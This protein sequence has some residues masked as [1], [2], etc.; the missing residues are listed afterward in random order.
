MRVVIDDAGDVAD[1]WAERHQIAIVPVNIHFGTE[2]FLSRVE[3]TREAFYR[4]VGQIGNDQFPKTS[5][6]NPYQFTEIFRE[7]FAGGEDEILVITVSEGLSKTYESAIQAARDVADLGKVHV[8]DSRSGSAA[9][10]YMAVEA[11]RM[12]E[13]GATTEAIMARLEQMRDEQVVVLLIHSLEYAVRGGR[14]SGLRSAIASL[15]NIKPLMQ[16]QD[17]I[18]IEAGKVRTQGKALQFMLDF[19]KGKVGDRPVKLAI[20]HANAPDAGRGLQ[21]MASPVLNATEEIMMDLCVPVAINL[22]PGAVGL[23]AIP[24]PA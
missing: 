23:V 17:G 22:G 15:L 12:A 24:E 3:M 21:A 5:Q 19:V 18:I 13:A 20:L 8:F 2:E 10:G 4:K 1:D 11:A 16:V 9:Q 14:V 7:I 6:P